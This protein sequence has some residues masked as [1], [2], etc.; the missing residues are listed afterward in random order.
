MDKFGIPGGETGV[1]IF[2]GIDMGDNLGKA[3]YL[4]RPET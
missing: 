1:M 2:G 4:L 3:P